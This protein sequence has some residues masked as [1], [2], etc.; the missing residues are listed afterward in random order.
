M[1]KKL[2]ISTFGLLLSFSAQSNNPDVTQQPTPVSAGA[3]LWNLAEQFGLIAATYFGPEPDAL[4]N[5]K[6]TRYF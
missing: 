3:P 5:G 4:I 1:I 6:T 2:C